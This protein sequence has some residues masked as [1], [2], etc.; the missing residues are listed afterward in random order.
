MEIAVCMDA[1]AVGRGEWPA[2]ARAVSQ[3]VAVG[4]DEIPQTY[5][6]LLNNWD[7]EHQLVDLELLTSAVLGMPTEVETPG[8][9]ALL[10]AAGDRFR[11][12]CFASR[13]VNSPHP[14]EWTALLAVNFAKGLSSSEDQILQE[15]ARQLGLTRLD[16]EILMSEPVALARQAVLWASRHSPDD[17]PEG[18]EVN[19]HFLLTLARLGRSRMSVAELVASM[20]RDF[21]LRSLPFS[22]VQEIVPSL[23]DAAVDLLIQRPVSVDAPQSVWE[24]LARAGFLEHES[25]IPPS[26]W[27]TQVRSSDQ[28]AQ[29]AKRILTRRGL[30]DAQ[31]SWVIDAAPTSDID[32]PESER[33]SA[34]ARIGAEVGCSAPRQRLLR[35]LTKCRTKD[36]FQQWA[37]AASLWGG[38]SSTLAAFVMSGTVPP[39]EVLTTEDW[40]AGLGARKLLSTE[41]QL[42]IP[43]LKQLVVAGRFDEAISVA[44][45]GAPLFSAEFSPVA[46]QALCARVGRDTAPRVTYVDDILAAAQ[47]GLCRPNDVVPETA[48]TLMALSQVWPIAKSATAALRNEPVTPDS[49]EYPDEWKPV[50]RRVVEPALVQ[51]WMAAL[52]TEDRK[53]AIRWTARLHDV[54]PAAVEWLIGDAAAPLDITEVTDGSKDWLRLFASGISINERLV[55]LAK[56]RSRGKR[57]DERGALTLLNVMAPELPTSA[58]AFAMH[59]MTGIGPIPTLDDVPIEIVGVF[60]RAVDPESLINSLMGSAKPRP[61]VP[62]AA[63]EAIVFAVRDSGLRLSTGYTT[64]QIMAQVPLARALGTLPGW[65]PLNPDPAVR[66]QWALQLLKQADITVEDLAAEIE[67]AEEGQP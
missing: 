38:W 24:E 44:I 34:A 58:V 26:G 33:T 25:L 63:L 35:W 23:S 41:P 18:F 4:V 15:A 3:R 53:A 45:A 48:A 22:L 65:E 52:I 2:I 19:D 37:E 46:L 7:G 17:R 9:G 6:L 67:R 31:A 49:D 50:L 12:L 10:V 21:A 57:L 56:S 30:D 27:L 54:A 32:W 42:L 29:V 16:L 13:P 51:S 43:L 61:S 64:A 60:A 59:A 36:E 11:A 28:L 1:G 20:H 8:S 47:A 39:V 66:T 14:N 5:D 62:S 40:S 55:R